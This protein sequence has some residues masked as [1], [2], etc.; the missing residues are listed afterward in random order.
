MESS[1]SNEFFDVHVPHQKYT[2]FLSNGS[3]NVHIDIS[4][5]L[6]FSS[7]FF[8]QIFG[9]VYIISNFTIAKTK[10]EFFNYFFKRVFDKPLSDIYRRNFVV[11]CLIFYII[12]CNSINQYIL[13]YIDHNF[14]YIYRK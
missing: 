9:F 5:I 6:P 3:C 2:K 12:F 7:G 8:F 10:L 13:A 11:L 14:P 4:F 1:F